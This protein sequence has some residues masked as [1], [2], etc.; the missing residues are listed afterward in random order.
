MKISSN[1][2]INNLLMIWIFN[3][4]IFVVTLCFYNVKYFSTLLLKDIKSKLVKVEFLKNSQ[5]WNLR[6]RPRISLHIWYAFSC[7]IILS[8]KKCAIYPHVWIVHSS[9]PQFPYKSSV[10]SW[11]ISSWTLYFFFNLT[12]IKTVCRIQDAWGWCTGITQR[13]GT[14]REV[15]GEF[16]I[17]N[18][19]TPVADSC[20]CMAK[21][22]QYCT[23]ISL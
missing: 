18:M 5:I 17:E 10:L 14:G 7:C 11:I 23:V 22:I 13:D 8:Q 19:C 6:L 21:P 1:I 16:R 2:S 3:F 9:L 4:D 20:W 15:G 12:S